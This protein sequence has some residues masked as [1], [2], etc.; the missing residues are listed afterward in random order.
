[1]VK[2]LKFQLIK[3]IL[4]TAWTRLPGGI[5]RFYVEWYPLVYEAGLMPAGTEMLAVISPGDVY[6]ASNLPGIFHYRSDGWF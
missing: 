4:D 1:M 6:T 5:W 2:M 3:L